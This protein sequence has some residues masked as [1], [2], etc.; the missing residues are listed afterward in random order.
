[1]ADLLLA[2]R[3]LMR[4][5]RRS[6]STLLALSIGLAALLLFRGFNTYIDAIGL[7][8]VIRAGGHA[9][10]QHK[11]YFLFGGSNPGAYGIPGADR[12]IER[13]RSDAQL[14]S[15]LLVVT[16]MLRFGGLAGNFEAGVSR[17]VIGTG[18]VATDVGRMR[19]WNELR[20]PAANPKFPLE[21][22]SPDAAIVGV[23]VARVLQL[24]AALR[25]EDCARPS[26]A[27][28]GSPS[29]SAKAMPDDIVALA[30]NEGVSSRAG[31]S[32]DVAR[33]ELLATGSRGAPNV[34]ALNVVAA[35]D[36]IF[37][38]LDEVAVL[39]HLANAQNLIFG[40]DAPQVSALM[41]TLHHTSD[42]PQA[43]KRLNDLLKDVPGG[44]MLTVRTF[45]ELNPFFTQTR[46]M[47]D[48]IF[49]FVFLLIGGI[50]LFT[51]GNTMN[52][53]VVERTV[54]IGTLRALGVRRGGI[55]RLFVL[56][57]V[58]LG[59]AGALVG[60]L[61]SIVLAELINRSGVTW[62]PPGAAGRQLLEL[63]VLGDLPVLLGSAVG[64]VLIATLSAMWPAWRAAKLQ[65]VEALRHV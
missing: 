45:E 2:L 60:L 16:P 30:S 48:F 52:A 39:I 59:L 38:E 36:Q 33:L 18:F 57:G 64:L 15:K 41:V 50:V 5:R 65:I 26:V 61:V 37:K 29:A 49:G 32:A 11:D 42:L 27:E 19:T 35:E 53:A 46:G 56:E 20:I 25:L 58:L 54:E 9:Q 31:A 13:I 63:R 28:V 1:M 51:V 14:G 44:N 8:T 34:T 10:V 7:S 40:R 17:T 47:F 12:L 6:V 24:C 23:G 22:T 55:L 62:Q 21:G 4:N 43:T 3:N